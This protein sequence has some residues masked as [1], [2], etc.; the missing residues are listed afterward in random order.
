MKVFLLLLLLVGCSVEI[1]ETTG[2][3]AEAITYVPYTGNL[4]SFER[5][6][7]W[8]DASEGGMTEF[9]GPTNGV[10]YTLVVPSIVMPQSEGGAYATKEDYIASLESQWATADDYRRISLGTT[11]VDGREAA[12]IIAVYSLQGY[13][14]MTRQVV[15]ETDIGFFRIAY[16]GPEEGFNDYMSVMDRALET[17]Q[18]LG[19]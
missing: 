4:Y 16:T 10:Q 8:L 13:Q 3:S 11:V 18:V 9:D 5:P 6:Q 12:E 17:F 1:G 2:S 19:Q 15:F 14:V 7:Y